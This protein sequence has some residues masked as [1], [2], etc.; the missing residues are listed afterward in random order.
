MSTPHDRNE[1]GFGEDAA[2]REDIILSRIADRIAGDADWQELEALAANDATVYQ[3]LAEALRYEDA[4][5]T[6][7]EAEIARA[8]AID[9]QPARHSEVA[10]ST[11]PATESSHATDEDRIE[12]EHASRKTS[13][14][15]AACGWAATLLFAVM[16]M[17]ASQT[18]D[19][20]PSD[21]AANDGLATPAV[22][23]DNLPVEEAYY[24]LDTRFI[25]ELPKVLV[26]TQPAI[27]GGFEVVYVRRIVERTVVD[28]FYQVGEDELGDP[29][30]I[31]MQME[32]VT[33]TEDL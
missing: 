20:R 9:L 19:Y 5:R 31:A 27:D 30:P 15:I 28:D 2:T 3:R 22:S 6:E 12:R 7:V 23:I 8:D 4:L 24:D 11:S 32:T 13:W 1:P 29:F 14:A 17:D 21:L 25:G 16:W 10:V 18:T 26:E 33:Q